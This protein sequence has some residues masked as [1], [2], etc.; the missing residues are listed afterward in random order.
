MSNYFELG[1]DL[2]RTRPSTNTLKIWFFIQFASF[3]NILTGTQENANPTNTL[4]SWRSI[5]VGLFFFTVQLVVHQIFEL[6]LHVHKQPLRSL[7]LFRGSL[8]FFLALEKK[9]TGTWY[10][11]IWSH[12][13]WGL[14]LLQCN[15]LQYYWRGWLHGTVAWQHFTSKWRAK[16]F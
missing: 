8:A 12:G 2:S 3:K 9:I 7:I 15:L 6:L 10:G 14:E 1:P 16:Q 11:V 4:L 5:Q 13:M